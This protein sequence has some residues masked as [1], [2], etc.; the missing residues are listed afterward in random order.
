MKVFER[1]DTDGWG[2]R[3]NII[4]ENNV[5]V[6]FDYRQSC[7]ENFGYYFS[8]TEPTNPLEYDEEPVDVDFAHA[9][10]V[11]DPS[12]MK[13]HSEGERNIAVFRLVNKEMNEMFL[14]L[15]NHHNGYYAHGFD[16]IKDDK[17]LFDGSL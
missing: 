15:Y 6:G 12:F 13:E 10:Y 5:L 1:T 9:D 7:C 11:F 2:N 17:T 14:V 16:M 8:T 4:D 3:L